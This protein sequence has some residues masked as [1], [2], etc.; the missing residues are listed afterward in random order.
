MKPAYRILS[1]VVDGMD[2][3]S[4]YI[5]RQVPGEHLRWRATCHGN[6]RDLRRG[7]DSRAVSVPSTPQRM[8]CLEPSIPTEQPLL[9]PVPPTG[10]FFCSHAPGGRS[11]TVAVSGPSFH[12]VAIHPDFGYITLL[13]F[14]TLGASWQTA[15]LGSLLPSPPPR[16]SRHHAS[17][18]RPPVA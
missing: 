1:H 7:S 10:G 13:R 14:D 15:V 8:A 2:A 12:P 4:G 11:V 6:S 18:W 17:P 5:H 9:P 3:S 16:V